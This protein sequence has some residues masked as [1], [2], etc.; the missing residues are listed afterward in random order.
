LWLIPTAYGAQE[1]GWVSDYWLRAL[2]VLIHPTSNFRRFRS[3]R[4]TGGA[5]KADIYSIQPGEVI[6]GIG[7]AIQKN[8]ASD[9]GT[10]EAD[11]GD[12]ASQFG[13]HFQSGYSM[14]MTHRRR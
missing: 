13:W 10:G 3:E 9:L 2:D 8:R 5:E 12:G 14:R 11:C 6:N 7:G 4:G 1:D